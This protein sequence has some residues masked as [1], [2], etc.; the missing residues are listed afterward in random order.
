RVL[1][2][3]R[4]ARLDGGADDAERRAKA[5]AILTVGLA[6][7]E[8]LPMGLDCG[9]VT[10]HK[11]PILPHQSR[12]FRRRNWRRSRLSGAPRDVGRVNGAA[13]FAIRSSSTSSGVGFGVTSS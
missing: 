6:A 10:G 8:I 1:H 12:P 11:L 5:A 7:D 9:F 3:R 13:I 4:I 2:L